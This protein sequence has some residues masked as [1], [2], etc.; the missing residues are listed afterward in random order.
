M[1]SHACALVAIGIFQ[2][3][4]QPHETFGDAYVAPDRI[5]LQQPVLPA[6]LA[7]VQVNTL[8]GLNILN[9]AANEPSISVDPNA[10]LRMVIGWR[11]FDTINSN[12]R[13]AGYAWSVDGGRTWSDGQVI[14][15]GV[16]RT[17]PV[18]DVDDN[19]TFFYNSL[20]GQQ[21][22][23]VDVW[24]SDDG[25]ATWDGPTPA[26]G[27]DKQWFV[28]DR[29]N[30][31]QYEIWSPFFSCCGSNFIFTRSIDNGDMFQTPV[32]V[33]SRPYW[34]TIAIGPDSEVYAAGVDVNQNSRFRVT[35]SDSAQH[36]DLSPI[37]EQSV[38]IDLGGRARANTGF[39]P[40][41][42]GL[43]GQ[44]WV[45]TDHSEGP[46]RGNVYLLSTIDPFAGSDPADVVISRS[47]DGGLT[48]SDPVRVHDDVGD[49]W[50][51]MGTLS[52]APNGRLDVLFNDNRD[53]PN[54]FR[55][56]RTYYTFSMDGG[57][58]WSDDVPLGPAWD[59]YVG[60]PNQSKI[61]DYY[62]MVSDR[63]GAHVT[64]ATT[65]NGEQDVYYTRIGD[66]DCNG[67]GVGDETDIVDGTSG[68]C[69][70]NGIPDECEIAAGTL[71]DENGDGIP[72]E[73]SCPADVNGDGELN[74][75]DFV[76]FQ[77]AWQM[78]DAAADCDGNGVYDVLDFVCYQGLFQEGCR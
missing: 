24:R 7:G 5:E 60:W 78:E 26:F 57:E 35:R 29:S 44:V 12:F 19:G 30:G 58:T 4:P 67:N 63:V 66:Y 46:T 56:T 69:N 76:A 33:P 32:T 22:T 36:P 10:P 3:P 51:W 61:G 1:I 23:D 64:Y 72:D 54:N 40:N 50:Q 62:Q 73:C 16:F 17:D 47:E 21:L 34:A 38:Q 77:L 42:G 52:V 8:G 71:T 43:W 39:G 2:G 75:L 59:S 45:A 74:V 48:W 13:Q 25:G 9:D 27:G 53:T 28:V 41:P 31:H 14:D 68:D 37:F 11:Q 20:Y 6:G 49:I 70:R 65:Y 15:P 55:L 18:L